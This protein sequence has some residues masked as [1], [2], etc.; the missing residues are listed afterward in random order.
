MKHTFC[1]P[2]ALYNPAQNPNGIHGT[3][4]PPLGEL[5]EQGKVI[6]LNFP[7]R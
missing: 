7:S 2:K 6:A 5:I 1:P 4:L 3:P